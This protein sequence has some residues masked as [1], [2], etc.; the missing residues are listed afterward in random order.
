MKMD[1]M[2]KIITAKNPIRRTDHSRLKSSSPCQIS[3][4]AKKEEKIPIN[5]KTDRIQQNM[6]FVLIP[7]TYPCILHL[8]RYQFIIQ[9]YHTLADNDFLEGTLRNMMAALLIAPILDVSISPYCLNDN[10]FLRL[11]QGNG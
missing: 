2:I 8:I 7:D 6:M 9:S 10:R 4:R 1:A 3:A 5:A 11:A